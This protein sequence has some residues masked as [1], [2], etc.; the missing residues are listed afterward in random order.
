MTDTFFVRE[1][2]RF[3]V[4][5]AQSNPAT[6]HMPFTTRRGMRWRTGAGRWTTSIR[7]W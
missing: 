5:K 6:S 2:G 7:N 4:G 3:V 1:D